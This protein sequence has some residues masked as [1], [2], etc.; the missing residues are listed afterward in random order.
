MLLLCHLV[1]SAGYYSAITSH[2]LFLT[3]EQSFAQLEWLSVV[4]F[5]SNFVIYY[6]PKFCNCICKLNALLSSPTEWKKQ[7]NKPKPPPPPTTK[8]LIMFLINY[9][10]LQT[11]FIFSYNWMNL[12]LERGTKFPSNWS[13]LLNTSLISQHSKSFLFPMAWQFI[14]ICIYNANR[15][16][17][18][19]VVVAVWKRIWD[20]FPWALCCISNHQFWRK[21]N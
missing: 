21:I 3:E 13:Y 10:F 15:L 19:P 11:S 20:F 5:F 8:T 2:S 1:L 4:F 14:G 18:S 16:L 7:P 17:C 6:F 12:I 9:L